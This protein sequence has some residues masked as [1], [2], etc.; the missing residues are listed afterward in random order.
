A[1]FEL[2]FETLLRFKAEAKIYFPIS[3]YPPIKRDLAFLIDKKVPWG[4]VV[5][6]IKDIDPLIDEIELFD[7]YESK[8]FGAKR[9]IAFHIVYQSYKRTLTSEEIDKIQKNIG[10]VL[11]HKFKAQLRD[12]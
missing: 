2:D 12:F 7:I 1:V 3:Q 8:R 9:N 6:E 5:R 11:E 4:Q 10:K